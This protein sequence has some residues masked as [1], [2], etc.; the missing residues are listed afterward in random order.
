MNSQLDCIPCFF[1]MALATARRLDFNHEQQARVLHHVLQCVDVNDLNQTPPGLW[2]GLG[3]IL[4]QISGDPDPYLP[5]KNEANRRVL[6]LLPDLK[7]R[8]L[9]AS[10]PFGEALRLAIAGNVIDMGANPDL[11]LN[12]ALNELSADFDP[13]LASN[14]RKLK[15]CIDRADNILYLLDNAGEVVFDTLFL[16]YIPVEKLTLVVRGAPVLNDVTLDD[17]KKLGLH[18]K[19]RIID[20][21]HQAPGTILEECGDVFMHAY[22][23]CDLILAKGQGNLESLLGV[24]RK[25]IFYMLK[26]KCDVVAQKLGVNLGALCLL[27]ENI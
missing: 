16:E 24:C 22:D 3:E 4:F 15:E 26:A 11:D 25:P 21:G 27:S 9:N 1:K 18:E 2:K 14:I 19:Y 5:Y 8:V 17:A 13:S 7:L 10:D 23:H 12:V 6:E 20:N